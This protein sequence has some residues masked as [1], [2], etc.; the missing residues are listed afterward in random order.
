M[1]RIMILSL[2][3]LICACSVKER[4]DLE[5][6]PKPTLIFGY[7]YLSD[8][9]VF[10]ANSIDKMDIFVFDR[11]G[12]FIKSETA[13][14]DNIGDPEGITILSGVPEDDYTVVSFANIDRAV[15]PKMVPGESTLS[16]FRLALPDNCTLTSGDR[17]F[18]HIGKFHVARGYPAVRPV[19]LNK[20]YYLI[21]LT[22]TG[23]DS[24]YAAGKEITVK[25]TGSSAGFDA[26]GNS[27]Q[28]QTVI[29]P[30]LSYGPAGLTGIFPVCRFGQDNRIGI[31]LKADDIT[32]FDLPL[33]DYLNEKEIGIDFGKSDVVIPIK[34]NVSASEV[35]VIIN[36]WEI[37]VNQNSGLG[38]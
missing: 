37:V 29:A 25:I 27:L 34:L 32:V 18:H 6:N 23:L 19:L 9:N 16:G 4:T 35:S 17:L 31:T 10:D 28:K 2:A 26:A 20:L 15:L 22:V 30:E 7:A 14:K 12:R 13:T 38:E 3:G 8:R 33:S 36:G 1:K 5:I 21:D 11:V 24:V